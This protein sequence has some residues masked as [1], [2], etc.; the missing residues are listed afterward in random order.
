V[1]LK[2]FN[3]NHDSAV[4]GVFNC[5]YHKNES[6]RAAITGTVSPADAPELHGVE[7]VGFAQQSGKLWRSG[8]NDRVPLKLGEGEWEV[9]SYAPVERGVAVLGLADK[10]NS[11]GAVTKRKWNRDGSLTVGLRDGGK[12]L[13][14]SERAPREVNLGGRKVEF[15]HDTV[16]GRLTAEIPTGGVRDIILKW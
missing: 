13:A 2:V 3:Y 7:F 12:F 6:E 14:W 15:A 11:T 10:L 8:Q 16:T 4:I 9:I 1:L 5:N